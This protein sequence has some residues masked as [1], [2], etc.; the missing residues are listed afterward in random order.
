MNK[1]KLLLLPAL[2]LLLTL[3]ATA[4][5]NGSNSPYSRYGFG[6]LGDGGNAF[7]K[8]MAGTAYGMR[9]GT[10]INAKNPASLSAVDSLTLLFD[11][12]LSLQNGNFKQGST[13]TN[14]RNTS[15]D[16]VSAAYRV[17][18][19]L[20]MVLGLRPYSTIGYETSSVET[21]NNGLSTTTKTTTYSGD[22]GL[23][24]AYAGIGWA[25]IRPLSVGLTAG[26]LWG[27]LSHTTTMDFDDSNVNTTYQKYDAE[28]RTFRAE[29]GLQYE[30]NIGKKDVLTLGFVYGLGHNVNRTAH[31]YN[32]MSGTSTTNGDTL[33]CARA[34]ALP[35]TFG[36]GLS[37]TH[38]RSLRIG[39][40][41]TF[42]KW[43]SV[44][45]P[46]LS[47]NT[48]T[49]EYLFSSR[50]GQFDDQHKLS[51]GLEYVP[52]AEGLKWRQRVRYRAGFAFST[53]YARVDG[54]DGPR[55]YAAT[56]GV[57]LP[58]VTM[59]NNRTFLNLSLGYEHVEPKVAGMMKENYYRISIG[60]TFNERWFMK[61]KAE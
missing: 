59:Y 2:L 3:S 19:R 35:H 33:S 10:E 7:N 53:P 14:A 16:Y 54:Q 44:K 15:V 60:L 12:G 25:P 61:W 50:K 30:Q 20:G 46:M 58:I 47:H 57:S 48:A 11:L 36:V 43:G 38:N 21:T 31:Y 5:T 55:S 40:D 6:L 51:L 1:L 49:G 22:G 29:F 37:W 17:A 27:N 23:H 32:V 9:G 56:A 41:Y 24:E 28:I 18:P 52:N 13:S 26:Y 42:L 34:F 45:Y 8:G 4:Q 39:A